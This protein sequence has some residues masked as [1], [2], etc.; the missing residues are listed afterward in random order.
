M[1]L[2]CLLAIETSSL[3]ARVEAA[4]GRDT[5]RLRPVRRE[6]EL[7]Q[8]VKRGGFD[9]LLVERRLLG[10]GMLS[11]AAALREAPEAAEL[12]VFCER[13]D[14]DERAELLAHGAL[15][16]LN[17]GTE[18]ELLGSALGTI[19]DRVE[20][21]DALPATPRDAA[22]PTLAD[23]RSASPSM[24]GLLELVGRV[25]DST[26]SLMILGE[27]GVG[28]EW[29]A[30]AIHRESSRSLKPFV[31]VNCAAIPETLLESEL[32]GH[33]QG[34]FTGAIRS[35]RGSF[36]LAHGGTLFLDEV[37]DMPAHMQ[38]KLLRVLQERQIQPV[39]SEESI[40][41]DV[42]VLAATNKDLERA[43]RDGSFRQD[44]FYRLSVVELEIPPL[45]K[46]LEDLPELTARTAGEIGIARRGTPFNVSPGA[47]EA[48]S[49]YPWPGN[50]REMANVIERAV[51]LSRTDQI[52]ATDLPGEF[53]AALAPEAPSPD[54]AGEPRD[55]RQVR[56]RA[57]DHAER[58]YLAGL[59]QDRRGRVGETA[60]LAGISER[61]LRA[62]M[63][64]LGLRK[65]S[66]R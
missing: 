8:R 14:P 53:G 24:W 64:R 49:R 51:L 60:R 16:V 31:A 26:T 3:R 33:E 54:D 19:L 58:A 15:A 44:L 47:L 61:A 1:L 43:S 12:V 50:L 40:D 27:T 32:F 48:M 66:Y 63:R 41:V 65:E 22:G 18:D 38:A 23:F 39:G 34:A 29:L 21:V 57:A 11:L 37:G 56:R 20:P 52:E 10:G 28:K 5:V 45:R 46:R 6:S 4:L 17:Q 55:L 36:E 35:R 62:R 42:R 59:L 2:R 13:E 30:R 9:L 25:C 7:W